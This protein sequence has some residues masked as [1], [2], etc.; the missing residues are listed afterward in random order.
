MKTAH[1]ALLLLQV[2][3]AHGAIAED[4]EA[5]DIRVVSP[6]ARAS[7]GQTSAG[8]VYMRLFN[9][10]AEPDHLIMVATPVA[11]NSSVHR[12]T[13]ENGVVSMEHISRLEVPSSTQ[14]NAGTQEK[15]GRPTSLEPGGLHIMLMKLNAPLEKG[16]SFAM[17][18]TFERAGTITIRVRVHGVGAMGPD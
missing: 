10:G 15:A 2:A 9:Q 7:A 3:M 1:F 11:E 14:E 13:R 5:G 6:W 8:V 17:A 18:L 12:T 16:G 4:Y